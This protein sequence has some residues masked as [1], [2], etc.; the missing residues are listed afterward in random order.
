MLLLSYS[1]FFKAGHQTMRDQEM[2]VL[3]YTAGLW[4]RGEVHTDILEIIRITSF[5]VVERELG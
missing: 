4:Q 5:V 1:L 2:Y 3:R